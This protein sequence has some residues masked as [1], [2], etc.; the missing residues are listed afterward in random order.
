MLDSR[1]DGLVV[2]L[3]WRMA[4]N[5]EKLLYSRREAAQALSLSIRSV[6]Y[7]ITTGRLASRRIG[8]K[9]LIPAGAIR[10]FAREDHP[11]SV[12]MANNEP[13]ADSK[14][15]RQISDSPKNGFEPRNLGLDV[16]DSVKLTGH[17]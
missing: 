15:S 9:V 5:V 10:R 13:S 1:Y 8:S 6:D 3:S 7:L 11:E 16:V 14:L 4:S 17:R 12:R 2:S